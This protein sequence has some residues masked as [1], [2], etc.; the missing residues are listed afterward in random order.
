MRLL[1][2]TQAFLWF[3]LNDPQLSSLAQSLI[4]D[5]ANEILIS[6]A[7]YGEIAIKVRL[8]KLP[9]ATDLAADFSG[10]I[11][12]ERFQPLAIS[13][14]HGI[15]VGLLPGPYKA[16]FDRMLI[17]QSMVEEVPIISGDIAF[18]AYPVTRL[19]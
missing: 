11:E 17:A 15:R 14:E 19:W 5:P 12:R 4:N 2:D 18:D 8:G 13:A 1:L 7:T 16:P 9:T 3:V 6:P 10:L